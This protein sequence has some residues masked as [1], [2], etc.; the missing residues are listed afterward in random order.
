MKRLPAVFLPIMAMLMA[1][2]GQISTGTALAAPASATDGTKVPHYFGPYPNW[3]NSPLTLPDAVVDIAGDGTGAKA[4]ATVGG[5]GVITGIRVTYPGSGYTAATVSIT[6]SGTG[7]AATATVT[8]SGVVTGITVNTP[9]SGYTLPAVTITGGGATTDATATALGGVDAVT[10]TNGGSLYSQNATVDFDMPDDPNGVQATGSV[11]VDAN[12]V[13]TGVTV[14]SPGSGYL[15]PPGVAIHDGARW[16]PQGTGTGAT[17]TATL[18]IASVVLDTFGAGYTSAP[19]VTITD[20][21]GAGATATATV[22]AGGVTLITVNS[23]GSGYVTPGGIRKFVDPL[24]GLCVPP[25][26]PTDGSKYIPIAVPDTTSYPGSATTPA[27]DTYEIGLVQYR[28]QFTTDLPASLER[29]YVQLETPA[30]AAVSQHF[31]LVNQLMDGTSL[32]VMDA[33]G[34]QYYAVTAPQFLGPTIAAQRDRPVRIIFR[35]LLPTG[36]D[37]NLFLPVDNTVMGSGMGPDMGGMQ[38]TDEGTVLDGARNPVCGELTATGEKPM[39]CYADSRATLHLHGGVTP[40]ISDGTPHQWITPAGE[41]T[42]YPQGVS[43][44]NV[45]DMNLCGANN[46]GCQTFYYTNQQSARLMF[47]HDHSWGITRLNVYAG[48]AAGYLIT[49]QTEQNLIASGTIPA[50]QLPLVIQD[51]TFVPGAAQLAAQDPTWDSSRW[52]GQG[53][54]WY[55]H[56][57]MPAQ[58]PGD[59]TGMSAFGRWMYGPWFWPPAKNATYPPIA[60]PYY[61]PNCDLNNPATWQYTT[62]PFCEPAQIPGTPNISVGMEQFNDTPVVNGTAYPTTTVDPKSYRLRILN[63]ANDRFWNLQWY[64]AD[65]TTGTLSEVALNPAQLAAAQ[66]DPTVFPT[67]DLTKSPAGPSWIQIG[68]EGGFLP[69]PVVVPNQPITWITDKTRFD[70]GNVDKHSLL[71]AP[72]ERADA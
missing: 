49:D 59:P 65:A 45:P 25:A 36:E 50:D 26:C 68:T 30:N 60:N 67:P 40:W 27:A 13:V 12:G 22:D 63:A 17:A 18:L 61:D 57:Y 70:F 31:P 32:P 43:V 35:N 58:N 69:A 4:T 19:T 54:L 3:A 6:G 20:P 23:P 46:D 33:A 71:L 24:P 15:T 1:M 9:G 11:T 56:V 5:N 64:V 55:Q 28:H 41:N 16:Q 66:T 14:V 62:S 29:G 51:R 42:A 72:A 52:G 38:A 44:Q 39:G 53:N 8:A 21:T 10:V 37:G 34:N 2:M 48:E 47:Y 7:A